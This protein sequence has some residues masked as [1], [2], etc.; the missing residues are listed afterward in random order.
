MKF[1]ESVDPHACAAAHPLLTSLSA[2]QDL[3][4]KEAVVPLFHDTCPQPCWPMAK[5]ASEN[6]ALVCSCSTSVS[7]A[8]RSIGVNTK[9]SENSRH[10][11]A[12]LTRDCAVREDDLRVPEPRSI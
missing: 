11:A 6:A 3:C 4:G 5:T 2:H 1:C 9:H 7:A 10:K 12:A 8:Q